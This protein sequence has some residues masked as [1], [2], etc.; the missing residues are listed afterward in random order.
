MQCH[1]CGTS[2]PLRAGDRIEFR[3][4]C[5]DCSADLHSCL[6]CAHHDP[7]THNECREPRAERQSDRARANRCEEFSPHLNARQ[8]PDGSSQAMADLEAL[9][10]K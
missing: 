4:T 6:N 7:D 1:H 2:V 9:F 3:Q 10:K 5:P 8:G